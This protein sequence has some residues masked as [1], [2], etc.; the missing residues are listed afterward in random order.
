MGVVPRTAPPRATLRP[1]S[2]VRKYHLGSSDGG[3]LKHCTRHAPPYS[4]QPTREAP[5]RAPA[6]APL[7]TR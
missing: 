4:K 1:Q 3:R 7:T 6:F 2:S 5:S